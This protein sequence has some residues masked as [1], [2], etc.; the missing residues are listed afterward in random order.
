MTRYHTAD[1]FNEALDRLVYTLARMDAQQRM[2]VLAG[3]HLAIEDEVFNL[4]IAPRLLDE[5]APAGSTSPLC[6]PDDGLEYVRI[7]GLLTLRPIGPVATIV[8]RDGRE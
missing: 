7:D 3:L 2:R 4:S 8:A 6:F 5:A 1:E